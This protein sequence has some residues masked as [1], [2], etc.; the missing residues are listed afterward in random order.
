MTYVGRQ[1]RP[2]MYSECLKKHRYRDEA[3]ARATAKKCM[4][5]RPETPLRTY[6]CPTCQYF[7]LTSR[8]DTKGVDSNTKPIPEDV[9]PQMTDRL[10]YVLRRLHSDP[11][12]QL[13]RHEVRRPDGKKEASF[14]IYGEG[15]K[16]YR[17]RAGE[18]GILL[19]FK[20]VYAKGDG[21]VRY[22]L[23]PAGEAVIVE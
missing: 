10:R 5:K 20:Y 12:A 4:D 6:Y 1:G 13:L 14:A 2:A 23:T 21:I 19:H 9:E 8:V 22:I 18:I 3:A 7:H 15:D 11:N 17:L 16:K